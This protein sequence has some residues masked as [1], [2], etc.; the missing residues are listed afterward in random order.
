VI[1]RSD[2]LLALWLAVA[3]N[4]T[5]PYNRAPR[6]ILGELLKIFISL[7][8]PPTY[9]ALQTSTIIRLESSSRHQRAMSRTTSRTESSPATH[10]RS[11]IQWI[12]VSYT[13]SQSSCNK[14][15]FRHP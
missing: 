2:L 15:K 6:H 14:N 1:V 9:I 3:G 7:S 10:A 4:A 8:R 13:W 12:G 5:R 11:S